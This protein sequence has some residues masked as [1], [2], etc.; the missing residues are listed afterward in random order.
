MQHLAVSFAIFAFGMG[1]AAFM[2]VQRLYGKHPHLFL[3]IFLRYMIVLN[4][5]VFLNLILHYLLANVFT[6]LDT[7]H[8]V[9]LV[10]AVNIV[11][12]F[13]FTLLTFYYLSLTRSLMDKIVKTI[14]KNLIFVII[15]AG[16][17]AYGFSLALY[18]SFS[19]I[20]V[21]LLVHKILISFLSIISLAASIQLFVGAKDLKFKS[22][23]RT[24]RIFSLV[25]AVFFAYQLGLW[26][27]PL[28]VWIMSSAFNLL[29]LNIIPIPFLA[30]LRREWGSQLLNKQD[31][32]EKIASFY[33][34]H[35][36]SKREQE[37]VDLILEG[38]SNDEI[39]DE[40]F[41]S[42][43]T[44]KKHISNIFTK[45]DT[46]S[47][48]QLIH[49]VMQAALADISDFLVGDIRSGG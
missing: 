37:I 2:Y 38:K 44:V 33:R 4:I 29:I 6:S 23:I 49:K 18:S 19:K 25:Y 7:Y 16:S 13:L 22:Q 35:G 11:G 42:I 27:L 46:N 34:A 14:E 9:M 39:K 43:F 32:K 8:K 47:R 20:S 28:Q 21:F 15:A 30:S 48:S 3:K 26:F 17:M 41:I 24:I 40:L 1:I 31:T 5:S 10:I 36:L 12:F 45:L